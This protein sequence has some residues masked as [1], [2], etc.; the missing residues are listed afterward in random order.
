[1][2][3]HVLGLNHV[4]APLEVREKVAFPADRQAQALADLASQ[5]GVAEAVLVSTCNRTEIYF[6]A[7]D[8]AAARRWLEGH[9]AR[10]GLDI[11]PHLYAHS[12]EAA[13][14][15]A[16]RVAAG[17]DSM[18]LGEPQILGQVKESVRNAE[19]A[20]TLGQLLGGVFRKTFS[21]AKQVRSETALGGESISMAAAA[22]KL[23][24]NIFGDLSRTSIVLVGVGEMV[25]LAAT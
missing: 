12:D 9:A 24:Q 11:G 18:V 19:S 13:V 3:L 23:A 6:R 16:F 8:S 17:L 20:G 7:D 22:L 25:E 5:P 21:V 10:A 2:P 14:R 4:S 1:M 15:H